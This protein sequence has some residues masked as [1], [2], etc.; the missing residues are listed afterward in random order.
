MEIRQLEYLLAVATE[1]SFTKAAAKLGV[2]QSAVS[3]QVAKLEDELGM[4]LLD[5]HRPITRPTEAGAL[6]TDRVSRVL[7]ELSAAREEVLGLRGQT[8]GE[9]TFATMFPA[10]SLDIPAI[11]ARFQAYRPAVR[12][13]LREGTAQESL[14]GIKNDSVD[15]GLLTADLKDLPPHIEGVV[16]DHHDLVLAGKT[17]HRLEAHDRV[18]IEELDG[19]TMVGFRR[20]VGRAGLRAATD[21]ALAQ[22]G[23]TPKIMVESNEIALLIGLVR[24]GHG[25]AVLP[26]QFFADPPPTGVW[27]RELNPPI[28]PSALLVWRR[29]RRY[30]PASEEFLRFIVA[31]ATTLRRASHSRPSRAN[32]R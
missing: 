22:H 18:D 9:V 13:I 12:V 16:A 29:G 24:H 32:D 6:F 31:E 5:R 8:V 2:A 30:P 14:E 28:T 17:G 20:V 21:A 7:A 1:G 15:I 10:A 11:L 4:P 26:R 3:H 27:M 23:V 19:E 25:L